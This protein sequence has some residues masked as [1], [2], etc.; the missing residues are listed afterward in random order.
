MGTVRPSRCVRDLETVAT[1]RR[2]YVGSGTRRPSDRRRLRR[3]DLLRERP[4][5]PRPRIRGR[6]RPRRLV[7]RRSGTST[8]RGTSPAA[9]APSCPGLARRAQ[10]LGPRPGRPNRWGRDHVARCDRRH[11]SGVSGSSAQPAGVPA[12]RQTRQFGGHDA[13]GSSPSA[14]NRPVPCV[15]RLHAA[16]PPP[17]RGCAGVLAVVG[18][19]RRQRRAPRRRFGTGVGDP[20]GDDPGSRTSPACVECRREPGHDTRTRLLAVVRSCD[21]SESGPDGATSPLHHRG[22]LTEKGAVNPGF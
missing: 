7:L 2:T 5:Q 3:M 16:P 10:R 21:R 1:T 12:V 4:P 15:P 20:M 13:G 18:T 14:R 19:S 17:P 9:D 8:G 6:R 11:P 22:L